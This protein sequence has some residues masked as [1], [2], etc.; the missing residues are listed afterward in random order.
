MS[1]NYLTEKEIFEIDEL[2]IATL[3]DYLSGKT[4]EKC[5]LIVHIFEKNQSYAII[6]GLNNENLEYIE[7]LR[8]LLRDNGIQ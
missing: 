8:G 6:K 4:R 7:K 5:K 2:T 3:T 1:E